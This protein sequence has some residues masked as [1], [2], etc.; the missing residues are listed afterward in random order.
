MFSPSI[1]KCS[2]RNWV[3]SVTCRHLG[4]ARHDASLQA[5]ETFR[6]LPRP[7]KLQGTKSEKMSS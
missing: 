7:R 5:Y 1:S 6:G 2:R 4:L 3:S